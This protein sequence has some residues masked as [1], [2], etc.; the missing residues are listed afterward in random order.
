MTHRADGPEV[1]V[2]IPV[3]DD[4]RYLTEALRSLDTQTR[5]GFEV[6]IVDDGSADPETLGVLE[7]VARRPR[8]TVLHTP[9]QGPATARNVAIAHSRGAY[10]VPLDA[11]DYLAPTFLEETVAVL[12]RE[13]ELGIVY[14]WIGLVG[15]HR[16]TWRTGGFSVPELLSHCTMHNTALYRREVWTDV[17]G[18]DPRFVESCEDWDFWL[19]AAARGWK[20]HCVPKV[21]AYYARRRPTGRAVRAA[22]RGVSS[23]LMRTLV[24]K[25]RD[26]YREHMEEAF[27]RLYEE[28]TSTLLSLERVYRHPA[29]SLGL[30][31]RGL[32]RGE[33][34]G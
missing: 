5:S 26:L 18:Y 21:L 30:R 11:D 16:G 4:G 28:Y 22:G 34:P 7:G 1:S 14:T 24:A 9:N 33:S 17:G 15:H 20:A 29:V 3:H 27:G 31:L 12:E 13:P 23:T 2:V 8:T 32:L 6:V 10:V 25:H 19:G